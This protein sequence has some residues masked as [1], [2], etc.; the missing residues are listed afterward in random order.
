MDLDKDLWE[1]ST[2]L[3]QMAK[4]HL[5]K[6]SEKD[7]DRVVRDGNDLL[8]YILEYR[9][10]LG[11]KRYRYLVAYSMGTLFDFKGAKWIVPHP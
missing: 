1:Y 9:I 10:F 2:T 8:D 11:K 6:L 5:D 3:E 7:R 4:W